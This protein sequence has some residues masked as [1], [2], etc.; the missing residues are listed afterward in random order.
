M[1][2]THSSSPGVTTCSGRST[3]CPAI[4]EMWTN[5]SMPSPTWTNDPNGTSLVIRPYTSSPTWWELANSCQGS[6]CVALSERLIRSLDRSTSRTSTSISSPTETT[7]DGWSTCFHDNSDTCTRPSMP[8][9]STKAP[10]FTTEDTTPRRR[11]PGLRL[12]RNSPRCSFW[13]SSNQ[14]RR[15]RTTLLRLRSSSMILASMVRPT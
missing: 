5:P 15:E 7:E 2:F 13:V 1:I 11:S 8:P 10:K 12:T 6:V 4:S 9:R 14:A 3:W